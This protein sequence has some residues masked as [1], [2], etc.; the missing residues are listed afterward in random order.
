M[1]EVV[2]QLNSYRQ[3]PRK[4]RLVASAIRGKTVKE[5]K[6]KLS[7]LIKRASGPLNKLLDSALANA[8][9]F[10]LKSED[11]K[12]KSITVDGG[13]I[14]YRRRPVSR[15]SAHPI[16]KRTS[17]IKLVLVEKTEVSKSKQKTK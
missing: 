5:A 16:K 4:V 7:F 3:S 13:K 15:G 6:A 9:N 11:L 8:K 10:G 17:H 14:L 12:I 1:K 2:A